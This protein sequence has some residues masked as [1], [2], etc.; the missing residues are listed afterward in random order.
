M[1]MMMWCLLIITYASF[2]QCRN[3]GPV[4]RDCWDTLRSKNRWREAQHIDTV[5]RVCSRQYI[6]GARNGITVFLIRSRR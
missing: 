5:G 3:Y 6:P 4:A 2:C 1:M